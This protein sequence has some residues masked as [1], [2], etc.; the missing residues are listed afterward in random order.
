MTDCFGFEEKFC[1]CWISHFKPWSHRRC[2]MF[3]CWQRWKGVVENRWDHRIWDVATW[4]KLERSQCARREK[5]K[6]VSQK[7]CTFLEYMDYLILF[8]RSKNAGEVINFACRGRASKHQKPCFSNASLFVPL[9]WVLEGVADLVPWT[10]WV[11]TFFGVRVTNFQKPF[12]P[13]TNWT[14]QN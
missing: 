12:S 13:H 10:S 5:P 1:R 2:Q 14:K 8:C 9:L 3:G 7:C 4:S 6:F 11:G